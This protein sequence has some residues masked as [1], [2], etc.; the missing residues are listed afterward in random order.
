M[1]ILLEM[2]K[3]MGEAL[4]QDERYVA[5][6]MAQAKA[7]DD[8]A[9]Q[10]LIGEFNLKRM[11][12]NNEAQKEDRDDEKLQKLNYELREAYTNVM[13]NENMVKYN[14]TK[15]ALDEC[16]QRV[17]AIIT[18]CA[19]GEDPDTADYDPSACTHDCST[20]GGCH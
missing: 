18:M 7:D 13:K 16:V 14:E 15:Q 2:A 6:Q 8:K 20:C 5:M 17:I 12:I 3:D 10:E 11:A 1:D 9:L 4:Q 19:E